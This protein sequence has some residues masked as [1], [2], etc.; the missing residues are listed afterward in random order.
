MESRQEH[1]DKSH[2]IFKR[3]IHECQGCGKG[4]N[5]RKGCEKHINEKH[6]FQEWECRTCHEVFPVDSVNHDHEK[7]NE[8]I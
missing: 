8:N 5:S 7:M 4:Y 1:I 2:I 6:L 3:G